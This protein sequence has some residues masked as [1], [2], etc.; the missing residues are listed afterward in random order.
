MSQTFAELGLNP[1]SIAGLEALGY[2]R[3]SKVQ[4]DVIPHLLAGRDAIIEAAP[5]SGKTAAYALPI[6]QTLNAETEGIQVLI[7]VPR[8]NDAMRV[9]GLLQALNYNQNIHIVPVFEEQPI[10]REAERLDRT[11]S[12]VVGTPER[13][14]QHVDRGSFGLEQV[15]VVV[16]DD[17]DHLITETQME[18]LEAVLEEVPGSRQTIL[19]TTQLDEEI[20]NFAD[21]HLFEPLVLK[22]EFT[23]V[24]MPLVKHRYQ[25]VAPA[26]KPLALL[27]LLDGELVDR[28]LIYVNLRPDAERVAQLLRSQG[29]HAGHLHSR[30]DAETRERL[31][32]NW[33]DGHLHF[34]VVTD[35]AAVG[36]NLETGFAIGYDVP[37]DA[38]SYA[39]RTRF[40][41]E[42]GSVFTL[43]TPRERPL[44]AQIE[45]FL[46]VRVKAV[47]PPTRADLVVQRSE[48]FKQT[49]RDVIAR[50]NLEIYMLLLNELAEEGYD[51]SEL[52]A[53]AVSLV[54]LSQA[55]TIFTRRAERRPPPVTTPT[56]PAPRPR[57]PVRERP[58]EEER[59]V[60]PGYVRLIMDA[61]YDIG[62]RPKDIVGA[63]AN[64]ANIPGRAVGNIDIRDRFTYVEI[65]E[66]YIDRVL[67]RVP[68]T[69]LR[70]RVVTFRRA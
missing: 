20:E 70:G 47:L 56:P 33:H 3:P 63:I 5:G 54:Q 49:L 60:E 40:V 8:G 22:T 7:F 34:I 21:Q 38:E 45:S 15:Q 68:S 53:A 19:L 30:T 52:A 55:E 26:E 2:E 28:G 44:L 59:E 65:Q 58:R 1:D 43:V 13:I 37:T 61:G 39:A 35:A 32:R 67:N 69:R 14:K 64:E 62:V 16:I 10:A 41:V 6:L 4:R 29:Y 17:F 12:I 18:A 36:L 27:R 48:N 24:T 9:A 50:S 11:V 42:N 51:W 46:G 66:E 57:E 23:F 31:L 25:S